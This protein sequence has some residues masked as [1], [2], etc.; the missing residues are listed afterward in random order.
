M[1][2]A[3]FAS[4]ARGLSS[5]NSIISELSERD[6]NIFAFIT[7]DTQI[8]FPKIHKSSY[9]VLSNVEGEETIYSNSLDTNLPFR[10]DWLIINRERWNPESEIIVHFK[11]RFGSKI[12]LVEP[13]SPL[14]NGIEGFLE[15]LSKNRFVKYIDVF[16]D[17]S[18]F[19]SNQRNLLGFSGNSVVVG[20]PKYDINLE[21]SEPVLTNLRKK[22][23]VDPNRKQ[24]LLFSLVNSS[25]EDLFKEFEKYISQNRE[26]QYFIKPYPGEPFE[27]QFHN[28]YFPEFF[29]QGV[30][31]ILD[32]P[33][34]WGMFNICDIHVGSFS[35]I[36]HSSYL[37]NKE[38]IDFSK[39]V[40]MRERFLDPLPILNSEGKGLEDK[41]ELWMRVFNLKSIEELK[42]LLSE[43]M[44]KNISK[45]NNK[46][47][48]IVD[49]L[50]SLDTESRYDK[51]LKLFDSFNDKKSNKRIVDYLEQI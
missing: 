28:Q 7:Q 11:E 31:P 44:I 2:V 38:V 41:S 48:N 26:Y 16:F 46:V 33:D 15:T 21:P 27:L 18:E 37:L 35:S 25:R 32:E 34:V 6:H 50:P 30:T 45:N 24:V 49:S 19:I 17:H 47:W 5:L 23:K 13:N 43:D 22:Y 42:N 39:E 10:P 20:N 12:G 51:I 4:D 14:I 9:K 29:I 36:F 1:N 8:R 40:R 3:V